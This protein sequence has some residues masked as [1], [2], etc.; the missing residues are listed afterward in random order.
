MNYLAYFLHMYSGFGITAG[1]HRLWSHKAYKARFPLRVL[2]MILNTISFQVIYL[3]IFS[4]CYC[5]NVIIT[6]IF[7]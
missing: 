6:H 5:N 1:A 7:F 3:K 4:I 2:L